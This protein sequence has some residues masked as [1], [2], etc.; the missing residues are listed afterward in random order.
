M[1]EKIDPE[2]LSALFDDEV[3]VEEGLWLLRRLDE[4]AEAAQQWYRYG[5]ARAALQSQTGVLPD[6]GFVD[7]VSRALESEPAILAPGR[8]P[9]RRRHEKWISAALAASLAVVAIM[10]ARSLHEYS[11]LR[12][13]EILALSELMGNSGP[14]AADNEFRDYLVSH[15]ETAYLSG[16]Q[17]MLPPVR[18]VSAGSH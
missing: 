18:L 5:I 7:R 12:G 10:V 4:D 8:I 6:S 2:R 15:Y 9:H 14:A 11:P 13:A 17:G 1:S 16:A 3:P